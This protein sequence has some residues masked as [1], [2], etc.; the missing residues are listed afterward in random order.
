MFTGTEV[1]ASYFFLS[2]QF[3]LSELLVI[4]NLKSAHRG[5]VLLFSAFLFSVVSPSIYSAAEQGSQG[6]GEGQ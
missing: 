5:V 4:R 1:C 3:C 2:G 6:S